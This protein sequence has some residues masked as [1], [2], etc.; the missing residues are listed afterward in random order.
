MSELNRK[1]EA[2]KAEYYE[3]QQKTGARKA[4]EDRVIA[5]VQGRTAAATHGAKDLLSFVKGNAEMEDMAAKNFARFSAL[6]GQETGSANDA[7]LGY[8]S[9]CK[10]MQK[11]HAD[12]QNMLASVEVK[13][14]EEALAAV[15][16]ASKKLN[17]QGAQLLADLG[18]SRDKLDKALAAQE[19]AW[20]DCLDAES[21]DKGVGSAD[22]DPWIAAVRYQA[23]S[24]GLETV[25]AA[26]ASDLRRVVKELKEMD[27]ARLSTMK[28]VLRS[29][30]DSRR[31]LLSKALQHAEELCSMVEQIQPDADCTAFLQSADVIE[32][33]LVEQTPPDATD[34]TT[35]T[36]PPP[37]SAGALGVWIPDD[38][39]R[40]CNKC[41]QGFGLM[42]RKHHCRRCGHV[43][44]DKCSARTCVLP[45]SFGFGNQQQRVCDTCLE[46]VQA[47]QGEMSGADEATGGS[48]AATDME[49]RREGSLLKKGGIGQQYKPRYFVC[50]RAGFLHYFD[51]KFD[52][53][54]KGSIPLHQVRCEV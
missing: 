45:A 6:F 49:V 15:E 28:S 37:A 40:N 22:S 24:K 27:A 50:T 35:G 3:R 7:L 31:S 36:A 53:T 13:R 42:R 33:E 4:I 25:E 30:A 47:G 16:E 38:A 39:V 17:A 12:L 46:L 20:A 8:S 52:L 14:S 44:C 54:P 41:Q 10:S 32:E 29:Y 48:S 23:A 1:R 26:H 43:F 11:L 5:A 9:S 21:K 19:K 51:S 34:A 2:L 18:S